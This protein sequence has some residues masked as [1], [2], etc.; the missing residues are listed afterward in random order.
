MSHRYHLD[1]LKARCDDRP[2]KSA[3]GPRKN[4]DT[5]I[6]LWAPFQS[7]ARHK[8]I[9]SARIPTFPLGEPLA[10]TVEHRPFKARA[11]G[12]SPRRLTTFINSLCVSSSVTFSSV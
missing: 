9:F 4:T 10:Q 11:L 5:V 6:G 8:Q 1:R 3:E 7:P 12:S 2:Q